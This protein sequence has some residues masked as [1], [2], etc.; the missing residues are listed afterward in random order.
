MGETHQNKYQKK[1]RTDYPINSHFLQQTKKT[2][3]RLS[4]HI[5]GLIQFRCWQRA[6]F[7]GGGPPSIFAAK[8]L[9]DRVRDGNGW[10]P[11]AWSPTN[12]SFAVTDYSRLQLIRWR[13]HKD[14]TSSTTFSNL[15]N[16]FSY[17]ACAIKDCF[18]RFAHNGGVAKPPLRN[19]LVLSF[20]KPTPLRRF[21][22]LS[23]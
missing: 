14:I 23:F 13:L 9:Y 6:I 2:L 15:K 19:L 18:V 17:S 22:H 7:P 16:L 4:N 1:V 12:L 3:N 8:S 10:F 20:D 11:L 21:V 5:Q